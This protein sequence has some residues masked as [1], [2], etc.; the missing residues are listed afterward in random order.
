MIHFR[1]I[2][3]MDT[4]FKQMRNF[5]LVFL[6]CCTLICGFI[7]QQ[8]FHQIELTSSKIY[9]LAQGMAL[10]AIAVD[11][12]KNQ[13]IEIRDHIKRFHEL[14]FNLDPDDQLIKNHLRAALY[15]IDQSGKQI[16]DDLQEKGY[17]AGL[18][19]GNIS[20]RIQIDSVQLEMNTSPYQFT[21]YAS[22]D[23]IRSSNRVKRKLI[24]TGMLRK[25]GRSDHNPHGYLILHWQIQ[26]NL[27][28]QP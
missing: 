15:L 28:L 9:V 26:S 4:A 27:T 2:K 21:C 22:E 19:S 17:Y 6:L 20:Q 18:I 12:Q 5:T 25:V 3:N 8:S 23:I 14:F 10:P 24:T 7:I 1:N 13:E 16:Y 11:E